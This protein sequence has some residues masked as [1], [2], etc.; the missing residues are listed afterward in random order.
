MRL[1]LLEGDA[2]LSADRSALAVVTFAFDRHRYSGE[3]LANVLTAEGFLCYRDEETRVRAGGV[4][5]GGRVELRASGGRVVLQGNK[6]T[7]NTAAGPGRPRQAFS[8]SQRGKKGRRLF[9]CAFC[10]LVPVFVCGVCCFGVVSCSLVVVDANAPPD[11]QTRPDGTI[12]HTA[13]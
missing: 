3:Q 13:R 11:K 12:R 9:P 6:T 2:P 1:S 4:L 7:V 10:F 5:V 8:T